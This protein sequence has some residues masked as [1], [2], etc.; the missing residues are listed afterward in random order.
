MND[1]IKPN[2]F[3]FEYDEIN[4]KVIPRQSQYIPLKINPDEL[5]KTKEYIRINFTICKINAPVDYLTWLNEPDCETEYKFGLYYE[6]DLEIK[7]KINQ[8]ILSYSNSNDNID[9]QTNKHST[10]C[11][12]YI[13]F[14]LRSQPIDL[15]FF[16]SWNIK[17]KFSIG[18]IQLSDTYIPNSIEYIK[19][20]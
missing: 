15:G 1:I 5:D 6:L 20:C 19:F 16:N 13:D 7:N 12:E 18:N 2:P 10:Y 14:E 11:S 4:D 8:I 17:S 9:K 3:E